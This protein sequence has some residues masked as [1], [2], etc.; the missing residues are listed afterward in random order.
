MTLSFPKLILPKGVTW[1]YKKSPKYATLE[2]MPFSMRHPAVANLQIST[3]WQFEL[4]WNYLKQKGV[5]TSNDLQ[6]FM[7]FYE[8]MRGGFGWFTFDPSQYNFEDLSV[9]QD[10][11][12]LKNGFFGIGDGVTTTFQLWRSTSALGSGNV[13]LCEMIQNITGL[14]GVYVNG[15]LVSPSTYTTSNFP[16]TIV[17]NTAPASG[18][19]LA[20]NGT[21]SYLCRF[22]EDTIQFEEFVYQLWTLKSLQLE[23]VNL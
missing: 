22:L 18:A 23:S 21:Y 14:Y 10:Y 11:T 12:Q 2:Q 8:A 19:N 5:T 7:E 17:F 13:T 15:A 3:I 16:A 9:T 4:T 6:Y 20:W 1:G